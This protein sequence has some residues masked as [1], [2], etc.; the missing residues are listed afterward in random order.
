MTVASKSNTPTTIGGRDY[1]GHALDG[2]QSDGLTPSAIENTISGGVSTP[3]K[4]PGTTAF[5]DPAN[6]VTVITD[7]SSGRV[8]TASRGQIKQ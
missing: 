1:T 3:G 6:D 4:V 8:V 7:T 2:M 5:Y